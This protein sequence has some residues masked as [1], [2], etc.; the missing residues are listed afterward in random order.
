M[1]VVGNAAEDDETLQLTSEKGT[2]ELMKVYPYTFTTS[3]TAGKLTLYFLPVPNQAFLLKLPY[4]LMPADPG[5]SDYPWYPSDRTMIQL[6]LAIGLKH[7]KEYDAYQMAMAELDAMVGRDRTDYGQSAGI[8][9]STGLDTR[10][11]G[12]GRGSGGAW[13]ARRTIS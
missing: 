3:A 1:N 10:V 11:F 6:V 7:R 12:G 2:P 8:N 13:P 4:L 9:Q 5:A